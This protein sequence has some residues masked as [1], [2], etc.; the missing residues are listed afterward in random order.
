[1]PFEW[2]RF[3][4]TQKL[5]IGINKPKLRFS[6]LEKLLFVCTILMLSACFDSNIKGEFLANELSWLV[7]QENEVIDFEEIKTK[8]KIQLKVNF[9]NELS[10]VKQYFP[11]EA[12][13]NI[14][15]YDSS[16]V[17]R[18]YLLKDKNGFK[19]YLRIHEVYR[20]LE[21]YQPLNEVKL[22]KEVYKSVYQLQED[23]IKSDAFIWK[24][25]FNED[26]GIIQFT[27]RNLNTYKKIK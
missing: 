21:L 6:L 18:I 11:I 23:T 9:K 19:R 26:E 7:Y 3:Y 24:V 5:L 16:I 12:E 15:N 1:M 14:S 27:D 25:F 22:G 20:P 13:V 10:Q 2:N 17:F 8:E 4:K